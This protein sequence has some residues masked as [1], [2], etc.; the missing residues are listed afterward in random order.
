MN[1]WRKLLK[2]QSYIGPYRLRRYYVTGLCGLEIIVGSVLP[3]LFGNLVTKVQELEPLA[4][5]LRYG[6]FLFAL[7]ILDILLDI[8]QNYEWHSFSV[9]YGDYFR[10]RMMECAFRK[11]PALIREKQKDLHSRILNDGAVV[12]GKIGVGF[13]MLTLNI[14][15]IALVLGFMTTISLRLSFVILAVVPVYVVFLQSTQRQIQTNSRK[16][17]EAFSD[18]NAEIREILYGFFQ[19]RIFQREPFFLKRIEDQTDGFETCSKSIKRYTAFSEGIGKLFTT[20]LPIIIL[21]LGSV[22]VASGRMTLGNLFSFYFYLS[23]LYEP[24]NNLA[25]YFTSLQVALGVVDRVLEFLEPELAEESDRGEKIES[26]QEIRLEDLSFSYAPGSPVL[27]HFSLALR[28]G[29][30]VGVIGAS[31]S[32]KTTLAEIL[33]KLHDVYSGSI[34]IN[35]SELREISRDSFYRR[36]SYID[37]SP[38][39][40]Q[41]TLKENI[42]FDDDEPDK[43][44]RVLRDVQLDGFQDADP[45]V[46]RIDDMGQN[47]SGGEKQ[48]I[49]LARALYKDADFLILDEFTSALDEA[50]EGEIISKLKEDI[51][52]DRIILMITH[53]KAPL[54]ICSHVV[55]LSSVPAPALD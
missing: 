29:D 18:L 39:I 45:E 30:I 34:Q 2:I 24:M 40:F 42:A 12:A 1:S 6:A 20:L 23:F 17:R 44:R 5:I 28:K 35:G 53:R 47:L 13:P 9:E 37:Q 46:F 21:I 3:A 43:L 32:G 51:A 41:G 38:F 4:A 50:T 33:M 48:R 31:G 25:D 36:L 8:W 55:E 54:R 27:D 14:L 19:I 26:V 22:E 15:R 49:A 16:E 7:G 52:K 10:L 11:S